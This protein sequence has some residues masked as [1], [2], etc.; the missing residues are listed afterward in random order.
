MFDLFL[1]LFSKI[2]KLLVVEGQIVKAG[3]TIA[4]LESVSAASS[5]ASFGQPQQ[6]AQHAEYD[7]VCPV[8]S[9]P[10]PQLLFKKVR[11]QRNQHF[12]PPPVHAAAPFSPPP[13]APDLPIGW[14]EVPQPNGTSFYMQRSTGLVSKHAQRF[15]QNTT[16]Y[17][18]ARAY[19][20]HPRMTRVAAPVAEARVKF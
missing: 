4:T 17:C 19:A 3:D 10:D 1:T 15:I 16:L 12:S 18:E 20:C 5:L 9:T 7:A 8:Q 2:A 6:T 14:E 13:P 11:T